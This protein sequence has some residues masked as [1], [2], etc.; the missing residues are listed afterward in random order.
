MYLWRHDER[1]GLA[2]WLFDNASQDDWQAHFADLR[3]ITSWAKPAGRRVAAILIFRD[4]DRPDAK[5]RAELARLTEAPGY[6]PYVAF[7]SAN[8]AVRAMLTMFSWVQKAPRY[9][10]DYFGTTAEALSWLEGRRGAVGA[11]QAMV[12]EL[13][14]EYRGLGGDFT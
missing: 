11:L 2:V 9:D 3:T 8:F 5:C 14:Q 4:F 6:D 10:M 7:V 1:A 13:R 12:K